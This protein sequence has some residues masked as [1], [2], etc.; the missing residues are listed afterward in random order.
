MIKYTLSKDVNKE[1]CNAFGCN[2][3]S[4]E[5]IDVSAGRFGKITFYVCKNCI[6][7]FQNKQKNQNDSNTV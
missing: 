3:Q 1:I 2:N 5:T 6:S 7:K 4:T